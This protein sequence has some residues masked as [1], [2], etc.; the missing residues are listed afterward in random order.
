MCGFSFY[1]LILFQWTLVL[2]NVRCIKK[3]NISFTI[4]KY[5]VFVC[6]FIRIFTFSPEFIRF[7][8]LIKVPKGNRIHSL[9][10][11]IIFPFSLEIICYIKWKKCMVSVDI[12]LLES[13]LLLQL[14]YIKGCEVVVCSCS[15]QK[16]VVA[17]IQSMSD[18]IKFIDSHFHSFKVNI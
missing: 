17:S 5:N 14:V 18:T 11:L 4:W 15:I 16:I 10:V 13:N 9:V 12:F 1:T 8:N 3:T 7:Y 6:F 2:D